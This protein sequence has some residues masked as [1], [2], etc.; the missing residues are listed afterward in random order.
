G[1][2]GRP[3]GGFPGGGFPG[4]GFGG[5]GRP[6]GGFPG[7]GFGGG[8]GPG[9][10]FPGGGFGG[11]GGPGRGGGFAGGGGFPGGGSGG[12]APR[13][14]SVLSR[15]LAQRP[16]GGGGSVG[17]GAGGAG[18][19]SGGTR[20]GGSGP[21]GGLPGG[22]GFPGSGGLPDGGGRP[23]GGFPGGGFPGGGGRPGGVGTG[24]TQRNPFRRIGD[25]INVPGLSRDKVRLIADKITVTDD[26]LLHGKVNINTA[27]PAVLAALPGM[28]PAIAMDIVNYRESTEG[29]FQTIGDILNVP[30][31][32]NAVF[33]RVADYITV[34][35]FTFRI[36]A[37]GIVRGSRVRKNIEAVIVLYPVPTEEMSA[38]AEPAAESAEPR[39]P[40]IETKPRIVYWREW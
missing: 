6:G 25:I 29:G 10:G 35:S 34:R 14:S 38:D 8:G 30:S 23:G 20:P 5:G 33:S 17:G 21:P 9:G 24:R 2:G 3:G 28:T 4:G 27:S 37:Q 1:G 36:R 22:G 31:V 18:R 26:M 12:A 15:V 16:A 40:F 19:P 39:I 7:G 11:G 13:R 32:T